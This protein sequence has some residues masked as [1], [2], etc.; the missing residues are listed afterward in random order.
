ML[1]LICMETWIVLYAKCSMIDLKKGVVWKR[2]S[3]R[4]RLLQV[5]QQQLQ[6]SGALPKTYF[7]RKLITALAGA[8][9]DIFRRLRS[10]MCGV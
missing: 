7:S 3:E 9:R 1:L 10:D 6:L 2:T 8:L 4:E 5:G